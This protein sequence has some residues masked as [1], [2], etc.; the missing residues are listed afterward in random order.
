MRVQQLQTP[1]STYIIYTMMDDMV[2]GC[3]KE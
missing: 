2:K 1:D 3:N